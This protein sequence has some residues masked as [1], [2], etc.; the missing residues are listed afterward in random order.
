MQN[1]L[2]K[3]Q[4]SVSIIFLFFSIFI[5]SFTYYLI[6]KS[7]IGF[8]VKEEKWQIEKFKRDEIK[9]LDHSVKAVEEERAQLESHFAQSSDIV[10][11]LDTIEALA[12]KTGAKAEVTSVDILAD[13]TGLLVG[14]KASGTFSSLYRF[15]TLLENSP[16]ELKFMRM[17]MN[18]QIDANGGNKNITSREWEMVFKVKL[19]SFI[20]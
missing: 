10:P 13:N 9:A 11:F 6:N 1:N 12:P 2:T 15:L 7:D 5:F 20:K 3:I 17:D 16:Y 14:M 4:L 19:L 18:K 8:K